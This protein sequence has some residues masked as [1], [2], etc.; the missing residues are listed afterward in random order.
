MSKVVKSIGKAIGGVVKGVVN[1]VKGVVKAVGKIVSAVLNFVTQPFMGMLGGM[2]GVPDA[3]QEAERQQGVLISAPAGGD[4]SIP[5]VYG[6]RQVGGKMTYFETGSDNNRYLWVCYA[7]SEG[8]IEG[9]F[10]ISVEDEDITTP[11]MISRLNAGEIVNVDKTGSRY[12]GRVQLQFWNGTQVAESQKTAISTYTAP[13]LMTQAPSWKKTNILNGVACIFARY[14]WKQ[15]TTQAEADNNPFGG[16]IPGIKTTI[17][18]RRVASLLATSNQQNFEW[19]DFPGGYVERYSTNPA[20]CLLD[21]L[22]NPYYGKGLKNADIDFTS[23]KQ[24]AAKY[25]QIV[26]YTTGVRG[27]ILTMNFVVDTSAT[28]MSNVKMMLQGCRS[29]MPYVKGKYKLK[30]EDAGNPT[31]ILSGSAVIAQVYDKDTIVGEINYTGLDR[32]AKYTSVEITYVSPGDKWANQ[33]LTYPVEETERRAYIVEDGNRE[34]KGSFTFPTIINYAMAYDMARLIFNKSRIQQTLT[35]KAPLQAM[36]LEP[37][38]NIHINSTILDFYDEADPGDN[39]PWRIISL[40]L[41][42]NYTYDVDC[43]RNPDFI[44][45]HVRAGERDLVIPPYVPR[46]SYIYYPG[47]ITDI[48]L[49]P[50]GS[51]FWLE[52]QN[53]GE[54]EDGGFPNPEPTDPTDPVEGG[55]VGDSNFV[56]APPAPPV[57]PPPPPLNSYIQVDQVIYTVV[58]QTVSAEIKFKQPKHPQ[59][60]GVDFWYKRN[61]STEVNYRTDRTTQAPG[62]DQYITHTIT[63]LVKSAIPYVLV[64]RVRFTNGDSSTF[65]VRTPLNVSGAVSTENPVDYEETAGAGW[66]LPTG[67]VNNPRDTVLSSLIGVSDLAPETSE[68]LVT[69][70]ITQDINNPSG[71]N[72]EVGGLAI[73]YRASTATYWK[74]HVETFDGS[75]FPGQ[76]YTFSP[77]LDIGFGN[78][79]SDGPSGVLPD[80][81]L[82]GGDLSDNFDFIYR[83]VYKDGTESTNQL[84]SMN[85]D[86]QPTWDV[87][88]TFKRPETSTAYNFL[89]VDQAP[90]GTVTDTRDMTI[91]LKDVAILINPNRL[92]ITI[93]PPAVADRV[94]WYGVNFRYRKIPVDGGNVPFEIQKI[95]PVPQPSAGVWQFDIAELEFAPSEYQFVI[96]PVVK[97]AGAKTEA[98]KSWI[99]RGKLDP[100][101][102]SNYIPRLN[103]KLIESAQIAE[104]AAQPILAGNTKVLVREWRRVSLANSGFRPNYQYFELVYQVPSGLSITGVRIY[105]RSNNVPSGTFA[106]YFGLGQFEYI[107]VVP[108]TNATVLADGNILV[109]LRYPISVFQFNANPSLPLE[110]TSTPWLTKKVLGAEPM[111]LVVVA[112]TSAGESVVGMELPKFSSINANTTTELAQEIPLTKYRGYDAGFKRNMLVGTDGA[113]ARVAN[114]NLNAT[115]TVAYTAPTPNRGSAVI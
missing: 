41:N 88:N 46:G 105:R 95:Y 82:V 75:Y 44:Y 30:V 102:R 69:F 15:V 101:D 63:G 54:I 77:T 19:G 26:T 39:I 55:G 8:P 108:G 99:G 81:T 70:T 10:D 113:L 50:P 29:Y 112:M 66:N 67:Q 58:G 38:D 110:T 34:N 83:L 76:P 42:E 16:G 84:R 65:A 45:P 87:Y 14:E 3:Q 100:A 9:I 90:P 93:E 96:T 79:T 12:T 21:Y 24:S 40:R 4:Y 18:G 2:G 28:L 37:G 11:T 7:L 103:F 89:T 92:R 115:T 59:Y 43:V 6:M 86:I 114:A 98:N 23:F 80:G 1:A 22:R 68:R 62:A 17:L 109:N 33:T 20:E 111:D 51:G 106:K 73:Y 5:V 85:T 27:P 78:P 32:S 61:I 60:A 53:P 52:D 94:N 71:Y 36:E 35:F 104:I 13:H 64:S 72:G 91:G 31:D 107:E 74:K 48:G 57:T 25:N 97:Y 47:V 49:E 56:G